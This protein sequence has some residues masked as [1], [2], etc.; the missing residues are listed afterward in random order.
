MV[1]LP[2]IYR[3]TTNE[4]TQYYGAIAFNLSYSSPSFVAASLS[5]FSG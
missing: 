1:D 5:Q 4:T 2:S 3:A